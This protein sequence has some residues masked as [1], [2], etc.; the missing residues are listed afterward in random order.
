MFRH[1][2]LLAGAAVAGLF[3]TDL[4]A[5]ATV[6]P[7]DLQMP[8]TQ[9]S[10]TSS[11]QPVSKC[12]NCHG[13]YDAL[14]EPAHTWRGGMM[15][16]A[17]RDP[18]FWASVAI[19]EQDF[20]GSGD[21][22]LRCHTP[23][24]WIDG[25]STPTDGSSLQDNYADGVSC[26]SCH[27]MTDPDQSEWLG[28]QNAPFLAHD[29]GQPPTAYLGSGMYVLWPNT[30]EKFGPYADATPNHGFFPSGFHRSADFCG[31][32]HDVSNP[33]VGDLAPSHGAPVPLDPGTFNGGLGGDVTIKAAFNNPP[34]A[35]GVV[36]RTF[37][38]HQASAYATLAVSDYETLPAEL[39][40]GSLA[41]AHAAAVAA[42]P[43]GNYVDGALRTFT[44]QTCHMPPVTGKGCNKSSAPLRTD[45]PLHDQTG[46]NTWLPDVMT[47]LDDQGR[48]VVGGGLN[49]S[50]LAAL[51]D[52]EARARQ[53]LQDAATLTVEGDVL[54]VVNLTGHKLISGYPEGRRMWLRTRW[55]D[56]Q[57]ALLR[58]DGGYGT[59]TVDLDGVS[60]PV[61]SL[62]DPDSEHL[63]TYEAHFGIT[64][65][66]AAKLLAVGYPPDLPLTYDRLTGAVALTLGSLATA[67]P[68]SAEETFHF[69]LNDTLLGDTRIPPFGMR[70]DDAVARHVLPVPASQY[71]DP[72]PGGVFDHRD[73]V[74]LQPPAGAADATIELLYQGTS[75]EYVQFLHLANDASVTHLASTGQDLME[76][77]LATGMAPPELMAS[78]VWV[79]EDDPWFDLGFALAGTHGLPRLDG[80]GSLQGGTAYT[81][82]LT[83][84]LEGVT[85]YLVVGFSSLFAPFRGGVLVPDPAPPGFFVA[86]PTDAGGGF[87]I[88]DTWPDDVPPNV[89]LFLQAWIED[90]AGPTGLS[91]S[92]GLEAITP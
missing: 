37:S 26:D 68:G 87:V 3:A 60:T 54:T 61:Q 2:L 42:S 67:P 63:R 88:A 35:Y 27:R 46:G 13:G 7:T 39:Q 8:G 21:L 10:E 23:D 70:Y 79:A 29:G 47:W 48:L 18:I 71:G 45:L 91:A 16:H 86:L 9:P 28:I 72:G 77:W 4:M 11:L 49:A 82:T 41:R 50:Q 75:W 31:T 15:S 90:P 30:N 89:S 40:A 74:P 6:V 81:V 80:T 22:C 1:H 73:V 17:T 57:G 76:A 20:R 83:G 36:E 85:S 69:V 44:C 12:D 65:A 14:V 5:Q 58:E 32:C 56:G 92:N 78:T 51:E 43:D 59:I 53:N 62:L 66:W 52:G 55:Y 64:Q 25:R 19:A 24:G 84:A 33:A 38:E 34:F